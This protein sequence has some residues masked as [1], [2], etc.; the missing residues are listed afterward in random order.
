MIKDL[1]NAGSKLSRKKFIFYT[2]AAAAA[3][4]AVF[5]SPV[6]LAMKTFSGK[7]ASPKHKITFKQNSGSIKRIS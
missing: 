5:N 6:K 4:A 2:G 1:I 7:A 3:I